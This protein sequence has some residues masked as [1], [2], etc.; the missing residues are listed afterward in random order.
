M[1]LI[2]PIKHSK[3]CVY[4]C[5]GYDL[6]TDCTCRAKFNKKPF[7]HWQE[8]ARDHVVDAILRE[9]L[10][11]T[12]DRSVPGLLARAKLFGLVMDLDSDRVHRLLEEK[13][14]MQMNFARVFNEA[15]DLHPHLRDAFGIKAQ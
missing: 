12:D 15:L 13:D 8:M 7:K 14:V 3:M 2:K 10:L 4:V 9:A 11:R 5:N 6:W 1:E